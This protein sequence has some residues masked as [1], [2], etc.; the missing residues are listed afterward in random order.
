MDSKNQHVRK[1]WLP[2][3]DEWQAFYETI[4]RYSWTKCNFTEKNIETIPKKAGIYIVEAQM[5]K[6]KFFYHLQE[7]ME[8]IFK[9][10][11]FNGLRSI[12]YVGQSKN[13]KDRFKSYVQGKDKRFK[14]YSS[15]SLKF[16]CTNH[17]DFKD[18]MKRNITEYLLINLFG[19]NLNK[20]M[21]I[22][23]SIAGYIK[24]SRAHSLKGT[25][26]PSKVTF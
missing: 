1:G 15:F 5:P 6:G 13:L 24:V 18:K 10:E 20:I 25:I 26:K 17:D 12:V 4:S 21:P 22:N 16:S 11:T 2:E 19:P 8:A 7:Q 9:E 14:Q 23:K 3:V